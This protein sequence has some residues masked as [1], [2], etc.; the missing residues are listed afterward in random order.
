M[1]L[2]AWLLYASIVAAVFLAALLHHR[3]HEPAGRGRRALPAVRATALALL[4]LLVFDPTLP[5]PRAAG[6]PAVALVDAS[7]SMRLPSPDGTTRWDEARRAVAALDPDRILTFGAGEARPVT[8]L[9]HVLPD[10]PSS[11]LGPALRSALEAG[12]ARVVVVTDGALDDVAEAARLAAANPVRVQIHRVGRA[13][14]GNLGLVELEAPSWAR[15][16]EEVEIRVAV[17]RIGGPVPDSV[18]VALVRGEGEVA[19]ARLPTPSE[20]HLA[21]ASLRFTPRVGS[22]APVRLE[23]R[24]EGGDAEPADDA[25]SVYMMIGEEPAGL[26]LVS[27]APDQEPRFLQPVLERALGLPATGWLAPAPGHYLRLGTGL[28]AGTAATETQ[29]RQ[30][31]TGADL[32]VLHGMDDRAPAWARAAAA[33]ARRLLIF[34]RSSLDA[35]P[36]TLEPP[37]SGDWYPDPDLPA[38]PAAALIAAAGSAGAPPL[39]AIRGARPPPGWWAPLNALEGRRGEP[40]PVLVAGLTGERRV[41]VALADGYW[42]WAFAEER[43]RDLYHAFWAGVAGWLMEGDDGPGHDLVRP[44][45][46]AAPRGQPLR[47]VVPHDADSLRI[48]LHPLEDG[49]GGAAL[50]DPPAEATAAPGAP[51]DTVVVAADGLAVQTPPRPGHY[52]YEARAFSAGGVEAL[53]T[54]ELTVERYSPEF[55]RPARPLG[56]LAGG[57]DPTGTAR[58]P[59][60]GGPVASGAPGQVEGAAEADAIEVR[61]GAGVGAASGAVGRAPGR[62]LRSSPWPWAAVVTLLC[63]EWALRR[64]WGL[65]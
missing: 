32:L 53:G 47:W 59:G 40:L 34:P 17:G 5:G 30:A 51:L 49:G 50:I 45:R 31:V 65:R 7:L 62:P 1:A 36:L 27:F 28:D 58:A 10:Q 3:R 2:S 6:A 63:A 18:S 55:T 24:I 41:A 21:A 29:V 42:R 14:S 35:L 56:A 19:R 16:G 48:T 43:G 60:D 25:R 38:S 33:S 64:R 13:S 23:A 26:V 39:S 11:R 61:E 20:G 52:R 22:D 8:S 57:G 44:Q 46:R 9:D 37:R 15:V 4:I 12:G 54:G